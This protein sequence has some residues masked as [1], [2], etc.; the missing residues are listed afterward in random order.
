LNRERLRE[1]EEEE[2]NPV[3]GPAVSIDLDPRDLSNTG[4]PNRQNRPADMRSPTLIQQRTAG[5]M[6]I[7]R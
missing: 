6:F 7:Q 4:P 1:A 5:S 3:G 2:G